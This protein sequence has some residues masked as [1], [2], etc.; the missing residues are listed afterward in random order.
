MPS[1]RPTPLSDEVL[2]DCLQAVHRLEEPG[3][4]ADLG[5]GAAFARVT[6]DAGHDAPR[7]PAPGGRHLAPAPA[8][9]AT[10]CRH[11]WPSLGPG[12]RR[13]HAVGACPD[14]GGR[15]TARRPPDPPPNPSARGARPGRPPAP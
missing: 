1:P 11:P 2:E 8:L 13:G 4:G 6:P 9:R 15:G 5:G 10:L 3:R 7:E 14:T 12:P